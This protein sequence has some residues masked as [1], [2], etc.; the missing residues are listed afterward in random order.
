MDQNKRR[1]F[2]C[3]KNEYTFRT[4]KSLIQAAEIA[5]NKFDNIDIN[6]VVTDTNS[7]QKDISVIKELLVAGKIDSKSKQLN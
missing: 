7:S 3:E 2:D 5:K 6:I 1:L 4:L